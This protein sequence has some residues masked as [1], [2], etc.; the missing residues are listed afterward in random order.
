MVCVCVCSCSIERAM[1]IFFFFLCSEFFELK[2]IQWNHVIRSRCSDA[3]QCNAFIHT[4]RLSLQYFS[5]SFLQQKNGN[6][7]E[8]DWETRET[9][10]LFHI[11]LKWYFF[12]RFSSS[13]SS[14]A[15]D[16]NG[17]IE[18]CTVWKCSLPSWSTTTMTTTSARRPSCCGYRTVVPWCGSNVPPV[19]IIIYEFNAKCRCRRRVLSACPFRCFSCAHQFKHFTIVIFSRIISLVVLAF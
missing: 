19:N 15:N 11:S 12:E 9:I 18:M 13:S 2:N 16:V 14:L 1:T 6:E 3:I 17:Y 10:L 8:M 4:H 7:W 5:I